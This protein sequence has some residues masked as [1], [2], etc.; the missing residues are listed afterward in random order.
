MCDCG[1][2][3]DD[4]G[5]VI[6]QLTLDGTGRESS[7]MVHAFAHVM[8]GLWLSIREWL[9]SPMNNELTLYILGQD[10]CIY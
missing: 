3:D 7:C 8:M 10:G 6:G 4:D 2:I 5:A 1:N 9:H